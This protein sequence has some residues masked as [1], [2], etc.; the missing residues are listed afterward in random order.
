MATEVLAVEY[1]LF[2]S[3]EMQ[4][5]SINRRI[6]YICSERDT[7]FVSLYGIAWWHDANVDAK[8]KYRKEITCW[9]MH[10]VSA[11]HESGNL[12]CIP[13]VNARNP[14]CASYNIKPS[15]STKKEKF[16][17]VWAKLNFLFA[18]RKQSSRFLL[19]STWNFHVGTLVLLKS[20]TA[21][22]K[23]LISNEWYELTS[24]YLRFLKLTL[25]NH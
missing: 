8:S 14:Q 7:V 12:W 17:P 21:F 11:C 9:P 24:F 3:V 19:R 2:I 4:S 25:Y 10:Q 23:F 15:Q 18:S 16:C 5:R 13:I 6:E 22:Y 20:V 1:I